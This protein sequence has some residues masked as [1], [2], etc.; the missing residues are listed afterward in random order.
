MRAT[1]SKFEKMAVLAAAILRQPRPLRRGLARTYKDLVEDLSPIPK[2]TFQDFLG[3]ASIALENFFSTD[4]NVSLD[5]LAF[6][7]ALSRKT[8]PRVVVEIG[9]FDGNT[10]LQLALNTPSEARIYTLDLPIDAGGNSENDEGDVKYITSSRRY[11]L[12]FKG[13]AVESKITQCYGNSLT[14]DFGK[15][16]TNG[17]PQLIFIDAGHSYECVRNDSEKA[18][19][20]LDSHGIII[21][22]DYSA[23]WPGVFRYLG[24]LC[25]THRLLHISGTSLVVYSP[26]DW[27]LTTLSSLL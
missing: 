8:K 19:K 25:R 13:T 14:F 27:K 1:R 24:E 2:I 12:R 6:I 18:L 9:T 26:M 16:T 5:E 17:K 20:I 7:A 15:F 4:G 21:W 11:N 22:Q 10:T 3:S 23:D